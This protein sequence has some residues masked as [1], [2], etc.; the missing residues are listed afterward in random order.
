M[1]VYLKFT[2]YR[3]H[4]LLSFLNKKKKQKKPNQIPESDLTVSINLVVWLVHLEDVKRS[5]GSSMMWAR[6]V[7]MAVS[8]P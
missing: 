7:N 1:I 6:E 4:S 5:V 3:G 2:C 8:R